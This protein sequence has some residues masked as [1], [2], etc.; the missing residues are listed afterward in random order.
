MKRLI[1]EPLLHFLLIGAKGVRLITAVDGKPTTDL[2]EI[3]ELMHGGE[4]KYEIR[5]GKLITEIGGEP[6]AVTVYKLGDKL[7]A[8]RNNEFGYANYE[9]MVANSLAS[10]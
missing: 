1:R 10:E 4:V 7:I 3:G 9:V 6:F 5:D 8:A 2:S